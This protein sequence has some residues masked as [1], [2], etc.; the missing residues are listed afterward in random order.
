MRPEDKNKSSFIVLF[1]NVSLQNRDA[2]DASD[3]RANSGRESPLLRRR[4]RREWP[5]SIDGKPEMRQRSVTL[6][7]FS[8]LSHAR[9]A[10]LLSISA[11]YTRLRRLAPESA[12][13]TIAGVTCIPP[14]Q[15]N[16]P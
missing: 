12:P 6:C 14:A 7:G 10:P 1:A 13:S 3:A 4:T 16:G 2:P 11:I 8:S 5:N 15:V 9:L